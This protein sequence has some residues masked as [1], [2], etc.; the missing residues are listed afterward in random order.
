M[1]LLTFSLFPPLL[2]ATEFSFGNIRL[3][4]EPSFSVSYQDLFSLSELQSVKVSW[5]EKSYGFGISHFGTSLYREMSFSGSY[6]LEIDNAFLMIEPSLLFLTQKDEDNLG[7]DADFMMGLSL[8]DYGIYL[9]AFH[10]FSWIRN[11]TIPIVTEL[12]GVFSNEWN[13]VGFKLDF[14]EGWGISLGFGYC[15]KFPN[16]T[17]TLGLLTN[18]LIPSCGVSMDLRKIRF[19]AGFQNHPDLGLSET[20]T[21]QYRR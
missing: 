4:K 20:F 21:V 15:V 2:T 6:R 3:P 19:S 13:K 11:N 14:T 17:T 1:I 8:K 16:F 12:C 10:P 9:N 5:N 18:P 7:F